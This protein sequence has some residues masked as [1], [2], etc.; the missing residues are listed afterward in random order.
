MDRMRFP[1]LLPKPL[2]APAFVVFVAGL[3]VGADRSARFSELSIPV[4]QC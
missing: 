3:L 2:K 4:V 1:L